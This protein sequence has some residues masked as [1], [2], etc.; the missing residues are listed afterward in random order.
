MFKPKQL[1]D[2]PPWTG[3]QWEYL[4]LTRWKDNDETFNELGRQGWEL[5]YGVGTRAFFKRQLPKP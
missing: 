3:P 4:S 5:V 1:K 2:A